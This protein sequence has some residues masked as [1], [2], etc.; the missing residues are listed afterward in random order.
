MGLSI[1]VTELDVKESNYVAPASVRDQLVADETRRYLD[2]VLDEPA[3]K[4]VTTWGLSDRH[5]WLEVTAADYKRFPG[6][7][8]HPGEGPGLN[9]GLPYDSDLRPKPMYD[10]IIRAF[11]GARP[12][13]AV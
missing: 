1:M 9:R 6:A 11:Q 5:S 2:A 4:G 3:V 8:S 13:Q 12:A 10:A 7:W